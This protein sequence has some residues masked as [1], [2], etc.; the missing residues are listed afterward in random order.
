MR[1]NPKE[2][3]YKVALIGMSNENDE[4]NEGLLKWANE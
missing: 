2:I 3:V 1:K 4:N